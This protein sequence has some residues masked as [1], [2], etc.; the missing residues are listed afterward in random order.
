MKKYGVCIL[1]V[2]KNQHIYN[3]LGI[4]PTHVRSPLTYCFKVCNTR[5]TTSWDP[6]ELKLGTLM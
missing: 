4:A 6:I 1:K 2:F 3:E 5:L